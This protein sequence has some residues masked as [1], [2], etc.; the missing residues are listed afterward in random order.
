MKYVKRKEKNIE[1]V[2]ILLPRKLKVFK[3]TGDNKVIFYYNRDI[4]VEIQSPNMRAVN[5]E[6]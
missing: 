2:P 3:V 4:P 6:F 1:I 5:N